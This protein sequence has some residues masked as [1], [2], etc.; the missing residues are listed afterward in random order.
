MNKKKKIQIV[1]DRSELLSKTNDFAQKISKIVGSTMTQ[2]GA[3]VSLFDDVTTNDGATVVSKLSSQG[4]G[5]DDVEKMYLSKLMEATEKTDELAGDGTSATT[6]VT[7]SIVK[8]VNDNRAMKINDLIAGLD[9]SEEIMLKLLNENKKELKEEQDYINLARVSTKDARLGEMI[10]K[11][12]YNAG[13]NSLLSI[14]KAVNKSEDYVEVQSNYILPITMCDYGL[15]EYLEDSKIVFIDSIITDQDNAL[16][17]LDHWARVNNERLTIIGK[18]VD[19]T[20]INFVKSSNIEN[21]GNG[22]V[23]L[24]TMPNM[25]QGVTQR[26]IMEDLA[27][28]CGTN[29]ITKEGFN[30]DP[31]KASKISM[32]HATVNMD[33]TQGTIFTIKKQGAV[34]AARIKALEDKLKTYNKDTQVREIAITKMRINSLNGRSVII[35]VYARNESALETKVMQVQDAVKATQYSMGFGYIGGAGYF[36]KLVKDD[37]ESGSV[38]KAIADDYLY[39]LSQIIGIVETAYVAKNTK[40]DAETGRPRKEEMAVIWQDGKARLMNIYE[41]GVIDSARVI[42]NVIKNSFS[43]GREYARIGCKIVEVE[44]Q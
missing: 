4:F 40:M 31:A 26:E 8:Y 18:D 41:A 17:Q 28:Y 22:I 30:N 9:A 25:N 42:E 38:G 3:Y 39:N 27:A 44:E 15:P 2:N 14:R 7:A 6:V 33:K 5:N 19:E 12:I 10:G 36:F 43:I 37:L 34:L 11:A 23:T 1:I 24:L 35:Y 32:G 29:A 13:E 20:A 16:R 21:R